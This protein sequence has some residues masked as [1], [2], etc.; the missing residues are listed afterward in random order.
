LELFIP[1]SSSYEEEEVAK[2]SYFPAWESSDPE[3]V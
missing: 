3:G 2:V 1:S